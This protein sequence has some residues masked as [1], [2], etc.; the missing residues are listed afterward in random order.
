MS[1]FYHFFRII[2]RHETRQNIDRSRSIAIAFC[3][4]LLLSISPLRPSIRDCDGYSNRRLYRERAPSFVRSL[5]H[6]R[7]L[8][9]LLSQTTIVTDCES[10]HT[11]KPC[12][13]GPQFFFLRVSLDFITEKIRIFFK[14]RTKI[15]S[16]KIQY[17]DSLTDR[18][19]LVFLID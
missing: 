12:G 17:K 9:P 13:W 3:S 16:R 7:E 11:R 1:T 5:V 8:A 2:N 19:D 15:S 6:S 4:R 10:T 18:N 14:P